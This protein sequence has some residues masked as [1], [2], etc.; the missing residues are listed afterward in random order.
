MLNIIL[1]CL[2]TI[3]GIAAIFLLST[4]GKW[5]RV[6][7]I[8]GLVSDAFWVW[9]IILT[10]NYIFLFFTL[11]RIGCYLNGI[12]NYYLKKPT[13]KHPLTKGQY[14]DYIL[15]RGEKVYYDDLLSKT[16]WKKKIECY[17][18]EINETIRNETE[19]KRQNLG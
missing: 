19:N 1:Q 11:A 10:A 4:K 17:R 9:W 18:R 14:D 8:S 2:I 7:F 5:T 16:L 12:R 6:G 13:W 15:I 3:F